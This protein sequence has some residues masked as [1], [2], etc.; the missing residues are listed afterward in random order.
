ML[1][2]TRRDLA[3]KKKKWRGLEVQLVADRAKIANFEVDK[4]TVEAKVEDLRRRIPPKS[5][6]SA[7]LEELTKRG[8]QL[9]IDFISITPQQPQ[10]DLKVAPDCEILPITISMKATYRSLGEYLGQIESLQSSFATVSEF[11]VTRD[12]R[13]YPKLAVNMKINTYMLKKDDSGQK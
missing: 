8:K 2:P 13:T 1:A 9:N 7:I 5:P 4:A 11:Q 10:L 3:E 12:E 6:T